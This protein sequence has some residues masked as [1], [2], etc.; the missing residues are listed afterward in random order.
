MM[1]F[2]TG[3]PGNVELELQYN[4]LNPLHPVLLVKITDVVFFSSKGLTSGIFN[5]V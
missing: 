3:S 2:T 4:D 1:T 5:F